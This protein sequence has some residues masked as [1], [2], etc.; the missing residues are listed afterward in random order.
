MP[1]HV[2][3][4][5]TI[6]SA[7]LSE[8]E[9]LVRGKE[10]VVDFSVLLPLPLHFWPGSVGSAH[11]KAFA[12]THLDA[13]KTIWGTKWNAYGDPKCEQVGDDVVLTFQTAWGPP[14]GWTVAMF[15]TL[16]KAITAKWLSEG[17]WP[18]HIEEYR[19]GKWG[20]EWTDTEL[21]DGSDEQRHL[22]KLLWG[23]EEFEDEEE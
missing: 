7:A 20:E 18:A 13:A 1:N 11:E 2:I 6:H 3:N 4:E 15:S 10:R 9:P 21:A 12:G 5:I 8:V 19:T 23:V 16:N 14:R 17:G 22:H